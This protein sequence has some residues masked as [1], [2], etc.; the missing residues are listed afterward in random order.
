VSPTSTTTT[1]TTT[2]PGSGSGSG[3]GSNGATTATPQTANPAG[4]QVLQ[5]CVSALAPPAGH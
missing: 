3:S 1:T 2:I 4:L 5:G